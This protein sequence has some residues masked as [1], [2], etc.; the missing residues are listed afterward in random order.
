MAYVVAAA[1][2]AVL[3]DDHRVAVGRHRRGGGKPAAIDADDERPPAPAEY[4]TAIAAARLWD[5]RHAATAPSTMAMLP[6]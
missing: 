6:R 3:E 5:I 2:E 4:G 1:G